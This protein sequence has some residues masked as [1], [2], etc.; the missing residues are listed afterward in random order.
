[1]QRKFLL[2]IGLFFV[3]FAFFFLASAL[4]KEKGDSQDIAHFI[5]G[6]YCQDIGDVEAAIQEYQQALKIDSES[7][8]IHLNLASSYI[9]KNNIPGAIEELN[10]AAKLEPDA[11]EPHAILALLYSIQGN[12]EQANSEYEFA[13]KA[14]AKK[15]PGNI[16]VYKSL[17]AVYLRQGKLNEALKAY[18]LATEISPG[19]AQ[20]H[21]YLASVYNEL[22]DS[23]PAEEELRQAIKLNPD[24][25]EALNFLGYLYIE[26]NKNL[27]EAEALVRKALSLDPENG[28]YIDSLGWYYY[29]KGKYSQAL[30][31]LERASTLVLDPVIFEHLGDAY[32]KTSQPEKAK[33]CWE[34]SLSLDEKQGRV[35]K[36]LEGLK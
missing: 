20:A 33:Q 3:V 35:K 5:M 4:T 7:C 22:K 24:Y 27:E 10:L 16:Q 13:L 19:D 15:E 6:V 34:K 17:G 32:L 36:K 12:A 18:K 26:Q 21:F 30:K 9:K 31:E 25:H 11:I 2:T 8:S 23:R 1:M 28:A 29:Q 14:A